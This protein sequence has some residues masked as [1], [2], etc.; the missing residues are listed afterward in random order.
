MS[1]TTQFIGLSS[2]AWNFLKEYK[3]KQLC[4]YYMTEGMFDEPVMGSIYECI[5]ER[6]GRYSFPEN[7]YMEEYKETFIEVVQ[8]MPWSS[9]PCIFT[10]LKYLAKDE[11]IGLWSDKEINNC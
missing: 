6:E 2:N 5:L 3:Y 1:R 11:Y 9:G 4:E 7:K 10:C 8:A